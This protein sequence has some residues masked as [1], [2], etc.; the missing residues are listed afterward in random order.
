M[1][2]PLHLTASQVGNLAEFMEELTQT[3]NN[4]GVV[5]KG[6]FTVECGDDSKAQLFLT[7]HQGSEQYIVDDWRG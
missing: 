7:Y 6:G 5:I 2:A 3:T 4:W 1:S